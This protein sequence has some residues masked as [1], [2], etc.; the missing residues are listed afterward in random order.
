MLKKFTIAALVLI[1]L[2]TG[3]SISGFAQSDR[4]KSKSLNKLRGAVS[5]LGVGTDSRVTVKLRSGEVLNGYISRADENGLVVHDLTGAE[6]EV[7]F[8]AVKKITGN[9]LST[10][11]KIAIGV[12]IGFT[13]AAIVAFMCL[14]A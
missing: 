13:I 7:P 2:N 3:F 5:I 9:N 11:A 1:V 12:G 8:P 6:T 4:I 10:G 14:R